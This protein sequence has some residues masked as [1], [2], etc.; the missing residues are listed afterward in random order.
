MLVRGAVEV[1]D[2]SDVY[3]I[4]LDSDF[5]CCISWEND[6]AAF[7]E[8]EVCCGNGWLEHDRYHN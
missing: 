3:Y 6:D 5:L 1:G 8:I 2:W 4:P 7:Y